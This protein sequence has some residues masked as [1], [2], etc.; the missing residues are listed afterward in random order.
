V[1]RVLELHPRRTGLRRRVRVT[2]DHASEFGYDG[3]VWLRETL[4]TAL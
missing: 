2:A 3:A 1:S 4:V